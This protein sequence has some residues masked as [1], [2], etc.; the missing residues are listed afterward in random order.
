MSVL[1]PPEGCA[2]RG[3]SAAQHRLEPDP[4]D[5]RAIVRVQVSKKP[6]LSLAGPVGLAGE[7]WML[8]RS[9]RA[10]LQRGAARALGPY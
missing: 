6:S 4:P 3:V 7:A 9:K 2:A 8:G 5:W 1:C 10:S